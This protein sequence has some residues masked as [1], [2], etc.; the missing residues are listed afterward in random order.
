MLSENRGGARPV[1]RWELRLAQLMAVQPAAGC[2]AAAATLRAMRVAGC[3]A[4][5]ETV[6]AKCHAESAAWP[7]PWPCSLRPKVVQPRPRWERGVA[8]CR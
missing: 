7:G 6:R 1:P 8:G 4:S 5:T 3:R 2:R